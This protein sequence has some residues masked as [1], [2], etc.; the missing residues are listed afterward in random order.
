MTD[1][2]KVDTKLVESFVENSKE[3]VQIETKISSA[4]AVF[5]K[6]LEEKRGQEEKMKEAIKAVMIRDNIKK[7]ENDIISLTYV[8]PTT[9]TSID[10]AKLKEEKPELWEQYSKTSEVSDSIRVKIK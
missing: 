10:T 8:A 2:K 5:Q 3:I 6:E 9:R 7:F 1:E 4:I